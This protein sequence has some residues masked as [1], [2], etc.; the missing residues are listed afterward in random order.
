MGR[1][2]ATQKAL[3]VESARMPSGPRHRFYDA[4]NELLAEAGFDR[5]V[6][7][8]CE[9]SF[10][11]RCRGGR[12]SLAPGVYFRMLL[13]GYFEGIESE[14]GI[15]WRC[16]DSLSLKRFLGYEVHEATPEHSTLS[17]MRS[18]L[19]EK[20]YEAVFCFVLRVLQE[21][22]LARGEVVGV[23]STYLRADASMKTIVRRDS[24]ESYKEYLRRLAREAGI[25]NA[26]DEEL[27]RM[28]R[29]RKG[30]KTSNADWKSSTDADAEIVRLK[31]G[32]TRLGYKA[33]HVVDME[34]GA[35]VGVDVM[36]ATTGDASS[37]EESL[38]RA[39]ENLARDAD[40]D[41]R[42]EDDTMGGSTTIKE[43]VADKGYHK[44]STIRS[45]KSKR[46][47]TYIPE[48]RQNG[49]RHWAAHGGRETARAVYEN[50]ARVKRAKSK[51]LQRR[52]GELIERSFAHVCETGQHRRVRL[53][54][55]SNVRK[56]YLIQTTGFNL[57]ILMR[58]IIGVG[59]PREA[60]NR[61][62]ALAEALLALITWFL[63]S[64]FYL[65]CGVAH[66]VQELPSQ[67]G[68]DIRGRR[69]STGC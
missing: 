17:R 7:Q 2:E 8:L 36:A 50:R 31:D 1:R 12:P 54:G 13:V 66:L 51:K 21:K 45:L 55:R 33:E 26:S 9:A 15:C 65:R 39:D 34:S 25:E 16:E 11:D 6:E 40:E 38:A 20:T 32:R 48:R 62:A 52:R 69:F 4:L 30:K 44:A 57:G 10:E 41:D 37:I 53:R 64:I 68:I 46:I 27:R 61:A 49:E 58:S 3:F 18:R 60:V 19:P 5:H 43:V 47:R 56:R 67:F 28:D 35:L 63:G 29:K 22:G 59:T 24:G 14:R 23:D 42:D